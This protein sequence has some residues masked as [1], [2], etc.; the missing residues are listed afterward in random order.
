M[1]QQSSRTAP[2]VPR[3]QCWANRTQL[4]PK[5]RSIQI[6][7]LGSQYTIVRSTLLV[8]WILLRPILEG[9]GKAY[10][11]TIYMQSM[12]GSLIDPAG[13]LPWIGN[14]APDTIFYSEFQNYGPDS[15]TE[16]RVKWKG[17]RSIDSKQASK[18][19][20]KS[21]VKGNKWIPKTGVPYKSDLWK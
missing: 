20:V 15:S 1:Q 8:T 2:F 5:G 4:P 21:F 17:L 9:L 14:T 16:R 7:T 10:S 12:L 3:S 19:T 18:F 6:K 13:W 11:T